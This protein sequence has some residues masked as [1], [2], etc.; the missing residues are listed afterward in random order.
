LRGFFEMRGR[1]V[2][3]SLILIMSTGYA[4]PF[5]FNLS[6]VLK[7]MKKVSSGISGLSDV[8]EDQ[9]REFVRFY[10]DKWEKYYSR[11]TTDEAEI[12]NLHNN[13]LRMDPYI[14]PDRIR[15]KWERVFKQPGSLR[16]E[17]PNLYSFQ[18]RTG[19]S[20]AGSFGRSTEIITENWRDQ[21]DYLKEIES[22]L[23]L[24]MNSR[25]AQKIRT[26][27]IAEFRHDIKN[28]SIPPGR[29]EIRMGRLLGLEAILEYEI[30]KQI[31]EMIS[32]T[33][34]WTELEIKS[35]VIS[36]NLKKRN[37][38]RA[39]AGDGKGGE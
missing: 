29:N 22:V 13:D 5:G 39:R 30:E 14:D 25:R 35:A 20:R 26:G 36:Q 4:Y 33:N 2:F 37:E 6:N 15:S 32:L 10:R 23:L 24:L 31:I 38:V 9:Y 18:R 7:M 17:F 12:F 11:F 19:N 8:M 16:A 1:R 27:K 3:I 28:Y 21:N 34:A